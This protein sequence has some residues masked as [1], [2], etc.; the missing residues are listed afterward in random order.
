M[1]KTFM[2]RHTM[3]AVLLVPSVSCGGFGMHGAGQSAPVAAVSDANIAAIV[4][5]AN[6]TD[7]SY[8]RLAPDRAT[9][10]S[11]MTFA[12]RMLA[13]HTGVNQLVTNLLTSADLTPEDNATSLDFRDES[14]TKRDILRELSGGA[15]DSTY[16]ANEVDYHVKLLAAIDGVLLPAARNP[17]LKELLTNVRPAVAGHLDHARRVQAELARR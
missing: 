1:R 14:A 17:S 10:T 4:L 5:A 7:I 9:S 8:A 6:N 2:A 3:W 12:A 15:F 16:M 11:V 13:D